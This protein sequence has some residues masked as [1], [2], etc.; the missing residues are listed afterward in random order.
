MWDVLYAVDAS[1]SM[2]DE[3]GDRGPRF[4][5][6][7][8]VKKGI[9]RAVAPGTFPFGS[10]VGVMGFRA[11]TKALGM[12]IDKKKEQT[13]E[14]IPLTQ[15]SELVANPAIMRHGLDS[16]DM[17]GAT[18][19]GEGIRK[20]IEVLHGSPEAGKNRI[21]KLVVVTDEKSNVG[22]RP[23]TLLDAVLARRA[24][25]DVVAI[26]NATDR[27]TF[28][29]FASR[30]GGT[31]AAVSD[32]DS[33][34]KALE[35]RIPYVQPI[36]PTPAQVEAARVAALVKET[37]KSDASYEGVAAA[38]EAVRSRLEQKLQE[39]VSLAGQARGDLDLVVSAAVRDPKSPAMSMREYADRVWSRGADLAKLQYIEW[40]YRRS[41]ESLPG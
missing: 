40:N 29:A 38:L 5:K 34:E 23:E 8:G 16:L 21:K 31:F 26:G 1:T 22:T 19:T 7:E 9:A 24:I 32:S 6:I 25:V 33:L 11:P 15:L 20:A 13:Q 2:G 14:V 18:P 37:K 10:R 27:R 36:P 41:I 3:A 12:M 39:T 30:T 4:V 28:E 17:G 35:P